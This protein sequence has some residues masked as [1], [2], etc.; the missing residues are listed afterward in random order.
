MGKICLDFRPEISSS[1]MMKLK[2]LVDDMESGQ[3]LS[4]TLERYDAHQADQILDLLRENSY[5]CYTKGGHHKEFYIN[6]KKEEEE[7]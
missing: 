1:E 6:A 4:I 7:E 3:E 5:K 2:R